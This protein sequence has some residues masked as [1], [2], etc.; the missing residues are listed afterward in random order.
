MEQQISVYWLQIQNI[1]YPL[2]PIIQ[3]A[4]L[5]FVANQSGLSRFADGFPSS[6]K[7]KSGLR[8]SQCYNFPALLNFL[9]D[10]HGIK[11]QQSGY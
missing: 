2:Y 1:L 7:S 6:P 5:H 10:Q 11:I 3:V 9:T 4:N 8:P